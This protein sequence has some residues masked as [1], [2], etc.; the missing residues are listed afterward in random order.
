[1]ESLRCILQ[2]NGPLVSMPPWCLAQEL[3]FK[4]DF[5]RKCQR[6]A[7]EELSF[8]GAN[9]E[10]LA[11]YWSGRDPSLNTFMLNRL[12]L[13]EVELMC[14]Q[15]VL[16]GYRDR[17]VYSSYGMKMDLE[18]RINGGEFNEK[19]LELWEMYR[20]RD[21]TERAAA[22]AEYRIEAG[23]FNKQVLEHWEMR[24]ARNH[25]EHAAAA[26]VYTQK[27]ERLEERNAAGEFSSGEFLDKVEQFRMYTLLSDAEHAAAELYRQQTPGS[28]QHVP[29]PAPAPGEAS[30]Q[31]VGADGDE[32]YSYNAA[33]KKVHSSFI[34]LTWCS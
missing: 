19:M 20:A 9:D 10:S 31:R 27:A 4:T 14:L 7:A 33:I 5:L 17:P 28:N 8:F 34:P 15:D 12:R 25:A 22:A 16:W 24:M 21:H 1:M 23:S 26:E 29:A 32:Q 3:Q 30:D 18:E 11:A 6:R 13:A 2:K